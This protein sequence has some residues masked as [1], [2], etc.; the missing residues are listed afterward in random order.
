MASNSILIA[1][2]GNNLDVWIGGAP[3]YGTARLLAANI[4]HA[5][6]IPRALSAA[7]VSALYSGQP[8]MSITPSGTSVVL[9][10]PSGMLLQAPTVL[11]PWTTNLTAVSPFTNAATSGNQFFRVQLP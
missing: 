6:I 5:A 11:G 8:I 2:T 10:W 7:E 9:T 4:A 1:P 3:D